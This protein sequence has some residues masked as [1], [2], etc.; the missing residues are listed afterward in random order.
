M[1]V[2]VSNKQVTPRQ[3]YIYTLVYIGDQGIVYLFVGQYGSSRFFTMHCAMKLVGSF[4]IFV[5]ICIALRGPVK[6]EIDC[7]IMYN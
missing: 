3:A 1:T 5:S 7:L 2:Y 6:S 4:I